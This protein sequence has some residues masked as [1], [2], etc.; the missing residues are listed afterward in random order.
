MGIDRPPAVIEYKIDGAGE[1][2]RE[3][4]SLG[5]LFVEVGA[6]GDNF[7]SLG[8]TTDIGLW[9]E[10]LETGTHEGRQNKVSFNFDSSK[11]CDVPDVSITIDESGDSPGDLIRGSFEA[12]VCS[13]LGQDSVLVEGRFIAE[14]ED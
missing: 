6:S 3:L 10:S 9:V 14:R 5:F 4:P 8:D 13:F 12:S 1:R 7:Y 11:N 2:R